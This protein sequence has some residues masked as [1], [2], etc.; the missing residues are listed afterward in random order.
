MLLLLFGQAH[1][2]RLHH[3]NA[4]AFAFFSPPAKILL[5]KYSKCDTVTEVDWFSEA[6]PGY[7]LGTAIFLL[8]LMR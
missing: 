1:C 6:V 3:K 7:R 5:D 8:F 4:F 2:N